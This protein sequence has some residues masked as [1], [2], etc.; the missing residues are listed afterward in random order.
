MTE[1]KHTPEHEGIKTMMFSA[2]QLGKSLDMDDSFTKWFDRN[3][4]GK[5]IDLIL[6]RVSDLEK[7][8]EEL[9]YKLSE[10]LQVI[11]L[12]SPDSNTPFVKQIEQLLTAPKGE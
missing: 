5:Q 4:M 6:S 8:N 1:E 10:C 11:I 12:L 9:R 2:F 3:S 7:A